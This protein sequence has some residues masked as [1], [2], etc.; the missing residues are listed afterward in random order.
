MTPQQKFHTDDVNQCLH[1]KSGGHG[2]HC[3]ASPFDFGKVLSSSVNEHQQNSNA[4]SREG[5]IPEILIEI[6]FCYRFY[7]IYITFV[8]FCL[9]TVI[10]KQFI[11]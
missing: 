4:S 5:Y 9:L 1:D 6:L 10:R 2:V 3:Y 11:L 7:R 8:A